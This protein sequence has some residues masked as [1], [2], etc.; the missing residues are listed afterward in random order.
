MST[1]QYLWNEAF[2]PHKVADCILPPEM[3]KYFQQLVDAKNLDHMTLVGGPGTGKTTVAR[4]MCEELDI[5]YIV[6]NASE[7]GNID[8]VRTKVR[9]FAST[10]S[11]MDGH[12]AIILDEADYLTPTA[13]A[14]LRGAIE[15]FSANCR[16]IFTGNYANKIIDAIKSRAPVVEFKI[17]KSDRQQ[18]MIQFLTRVEEVLKDKGIL[19]SV[20]ELVQVVKKNFPDYR[21]TWNLLQRYC[22][23]G[24]L[25]INSQQGITEATLKELTTLLKESNFTEM[26]KWIVDNLDNDGAALRRAIYDKVSLE[27]KK[28]SIPNLVL[29]LAEY[30]YKEAFVV[31]KEI[32]MVACLTTIMTECNFE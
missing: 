19:Y 9:Q 32:N 18:L 3:K 23:T 2:R 7:E 14:A 4:A 28:A 1:E 10:V 15:E 22:A 30:D 20:E 8:T 25:K 17:D 6:I 24:E 21:K 26:R 11:L 13:Q 5:D 29:I 31:D 16:F 12:K 27:M